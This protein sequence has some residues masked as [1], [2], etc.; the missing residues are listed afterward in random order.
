MQSD[1]EGNPLID[2]KRLL[3]YDLFY[4]TG[5]VRVFKDPPQYK[6]NQKKFAKLLIGEEGFSKLEDKSFFENGWSI[7]IYNYNNRKFEDKEIV[8]CASLMYS[9]AKKALIWLE[10]CPVNG[11]TFGIYKIK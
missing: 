4:E 11:Q 1:K 10:D 7:D 3:T 9:K 8:L 6:E 2:Y 5:V